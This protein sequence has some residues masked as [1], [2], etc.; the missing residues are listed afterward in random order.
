MPPELVQERG[1]GHSGGRDVHKPGGG[2]EGPGASGAAEQVTSFFV[3]LSQNKQC[4]ILFLTK[5]TSD[6]VIFIIE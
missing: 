2:H 6:F 5:E 1:T 3:D 4:K